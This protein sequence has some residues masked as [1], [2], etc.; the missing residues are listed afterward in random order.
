[1]GTTPQPA[2]SAL[3]IQ[4]AIV[5]STNSSDFILQALMLLKKTHLNNDM[6]ISIGQYLLLYLMA[7]ELR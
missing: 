6:A 5:I 4:L 3:S 2:P 7:I 1:M